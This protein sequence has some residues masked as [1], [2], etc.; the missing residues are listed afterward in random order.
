MQNLKISEIERLFSVEDCHSPREV[1][2]EKLID[3][4][5]YL[6]ISCRKILDIIV[7]H[8]VYITILDRERLH[9]VIREIVGD[10]FAK[11]II[12]IDFILGRH[13]GASQRNLQSHQAQ[14]DI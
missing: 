3:V 12:F 5:D 7:H 9:W 8:P 2:Q 4:L 10:Y 14:E 13:R 6:A 1:I 11:Y